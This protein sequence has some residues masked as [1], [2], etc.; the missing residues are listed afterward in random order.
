[1]KKAAG[2]I[3]FNSEDK[4]LIEHPT[5]HDPNFWSFPKG[6]VDE[7][8]T[9]FE[10]AVRE[11]YEETFLDLNK[12]DYRVLKELPE[13]LFKNKRKRLKLF[14]LKVNKTLYDF[15]FKCTSMVEKNRDGSLRENPFPEVD[16]YKWATLE[17][18]YPLLH[19]SQQRAVDGI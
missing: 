18:A 17:E 15:P 19:E 7:G 2:I 8:E 9:Y 1:M 14:V 3:L 13:I 16:D 12:I 4:V 11:T 10:A 6:M 5:N